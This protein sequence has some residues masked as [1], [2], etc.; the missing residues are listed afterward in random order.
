MEYIYYINTPKG[1]YNYH[2]FKYKMPIFGELFFAI[3]FSRFMKAMLLNLQN[4]MRIQDSLDVAKNVV[5]NYVSII[6]NRN[7]NKQ[8]YNGKFMDRTI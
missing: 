6:N 1:K 3:D 4:G 5:Q 2:L 7:I 8:Y